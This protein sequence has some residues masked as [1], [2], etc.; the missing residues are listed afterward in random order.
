MTGQSGQSLQTCLKEAGAAHAQALRGD[1]DDGAADYARNAN[2]RCL[3]LPDEQRQAC[4][5]RMAGAGTTTGSAATGGIY[6]E[7][8]TTE[9]VKPD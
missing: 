7:L 9:P 6:R 1:L 4:A 3:R 2:L 5:A 8:V